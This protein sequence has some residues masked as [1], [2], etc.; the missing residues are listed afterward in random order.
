M[1]KGCYSLLPA[2][3]WYQSPLWMSSSMSLI[4]REHGGVHDQCYKADSWRFGDLNRR[5]IC[6]VV[7]FGTHLKF[8]FFLS[9]SLF[10]SPGWQPQAYMLLWSVQ[11]DISLICF[12][13][14]TSEVH[15]TKNPPKRIIITNNMPENKSRYNSN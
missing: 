14:G 13:A 1:T 9:L 5:H 11:T 15:N 2:T 7:S 6:N 12:N 4:M 3:F 10:L 8:I